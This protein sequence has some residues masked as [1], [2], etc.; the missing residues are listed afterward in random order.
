[1]DPRQKAVW[2][3]IRKKALTEKKALD[4]ETR[5][6]VVSFLEKAWHD[7]DST[8]VILGALSFITGRLTGY[9]WFKNKIKVKKDQSLYGRLVEL[10]NV[11]IIKLKGVGS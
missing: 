8:A 5:E 10:L 6:V 9:R 3:K 4:L 11:L 2:K 1:M 7:L